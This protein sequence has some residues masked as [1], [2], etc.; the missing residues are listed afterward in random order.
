MAKKDLFNINSFV[1]S[2]QESYKDIIDVPI[3]SH[4]L[5]NEKV[6]YNTTVNSALVKENILDSFAEPLS[7]E[8]DWGKI[9]PYL[10]IVICEDEKRT[11]NY[12]S[13]FISKIKN[14]R[15]Q[16]IPIN[17]VGGIPFPKMVETAN[18]E[19][20]G[21]GLNFDEGDSLFLISDLDHYRE[22]ILKEVISD[23]W[24]EKYKLIISNPCIEIWFYYHFREDYPNIDIKDKNERQIPG[25]MKKHNS[26]IIAGGVNHLLLAN[27]TD[28]DTAIKNSKRN[29]SLEDNG[30][31]PSLFS[32]QMYI[33]A[34]ILKDAME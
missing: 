17:K 27:N 24:N 16:L 7:Y 3:P 28:I 21:K 9:D 26:S 1:Y 12:F 2:K 31:I 34:E 13:E 30:V 29:F 8:K 33:V 4:K 32:T 25:L 6:V 19:A 23:T 18:C 15:Y 10:I 11:Y 22:S 14:S 5:A 20:K